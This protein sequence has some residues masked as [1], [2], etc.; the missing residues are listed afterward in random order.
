VQEASRGLLVIGMIENRKTVDAL[1]ELLSVDQIDA[2][3]IGCID[4]AQ[5]K[6]WTGRIG[7]SWMPQSPES[8][9]AVVKPGSL[10][11]WALSRLGALGIG[12]SGWTLESKSSTSHRHIS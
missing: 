6:Q 2:S 12:P 3:H 11:Q 8:C 10:P 7:P 4:F 1:D 9:A 5:S